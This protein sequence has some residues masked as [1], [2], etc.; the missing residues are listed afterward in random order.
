M[1][2]QYLERSLE[3]GYFC[4][5]K[6]WPVKDTRKTRERLSLQRKQLFIF[7]VNLHVYS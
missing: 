7:S 6:I 2:I 5:K 3:K 4:I 1:N